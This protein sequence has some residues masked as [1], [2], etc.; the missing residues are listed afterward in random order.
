[1]IPGIINQRRYKNLKIYYLKLFFVLVLLLI[2]FYLFSCSSMLDCN[3][4]MS[5][6]EMIKAFSKGIRNA[7]I[8]VGIIQNGQMSYTVYGENGKELPNKEYTYDIGSCTKAITGHLFARAIYEN[9]IT[10][11]NIDDSIDLYLDLPKKDY[12]PIIR[13][14]LTH[15]SGYKYFRDDTLQLLFPPLST[16]FENPYYG[17]TREMVIDHIGS[18]NL[19][20]KDYEWVYSNFGLSVAG[21]VLESIFKEDYSSLVRRYFKSLGLNN[22]K[23]SDGKGDLSYSWNWNSGNPF[24]AAGGIA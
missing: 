22:T 7:R 3:E 13:R 5:S 20:N 9:L 18:I 19:E 24:I 8:T 10:L 6:T 16:P 11:E 2:S 14:I 4:N 21:L 23:V 15:T 17:L 12:Y 1:M